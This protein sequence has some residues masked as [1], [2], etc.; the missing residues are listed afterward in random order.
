[1]RRRFAWLTPVVLTLIVAAVFVLP[2]G[3]R[4]E[5]P[6]T[7]MQRLR[8]EMWKEHVPP[9]IAEPDLGQEAK[10]DSGAVSS[11]GGL[12][13]WSRIVFQSY[14]DG[15]WEI[16]LAWG[17]GSRQTR[18]TNNSAS[19]ARPRLNRGAT[20]VVFESNR[21][22]NWEIYSM[23][24]D[25]SGVKRLT[26]NP[27]DETTAAW[28]P[29]GKKIAFA[30][31]R[32]GNYEIYVMNADGS[33]VRRLTNNS[34]DD[35]SPTWSLDGTRIAWARMAQGAYD[36]SIWTMKPDGANQSK[37]SGLLRLWFLQNVVWQP[38]SL[39]PSFGCDYDV[40]MDLWNEVALLYGWVVAIHDAGAM[41]DTW[42]GSWKPVPD[43]PS[44][45]DYTDLLF[46]RVE[47]VVQNN[48]LYIRAAYIEKHPGPSAP[49][50]M[51]PVRLISSGLDL[52]PDWQ[53]LD[54]TPPVVRV[55][56]LPPFSRTPG[57]TL[58]WSAQ[59]V[60]PAGVRNYGV[61]TKVNNGAWAECFPDGSYTTCLED[62]RDTS[63]TIRG[64]PGY[65][66]GFRVR[67]WDNAGNLQPW[68]GDEPDVKTTFY[69]WLLTGSVRDARGKLIP[70]ARVTG[71]PA[72]AVP[73][74]TNAYGDY[75]A[76]L[77]AEHTQAVRPT[78]LGYHAPPETILNLTADGTLNLVLVPT[79]N[80]ITDGG[81][82]GSVLTDA[83]APFGEPRPKA[84]A[85]TRHSGAQSLELGWPDGTSEADVDSG[86]RQQVII[87]ATL[88]RPTLS[89]L[90]H[91]RNGDCGDS[92]VIAGV[93]D[94]TGAEFLPVAVNSLGNWQ[95]AWADVGEW[96]G[97]TVTV[98][99]G[100]RQPAGAAQQNMYIDEVTLGSWLT[101]VIHEI[102]PSVIQP[103]ADTMVT[104][105][106]ENFAATPEVRFDNIVLRN[107]EFVDEQT[108]RITV[109]ADFRPGVFD[110]WV[111]NPRGHV[112]ALPG[113]MQ[114][115]VQH[116]IPMVSKSY[117]P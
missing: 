108:L 13:D 45:Y 89:L 47:Y 21:D 29:D 78:R 72:P 107:V 25:G 2:F 18:L 31:K 14:R 70:G 48:R 26:N 106:G 10:P 58:S 46:S 114:K 6:V 112:T 105:T 23:N 82:E 68:R 57:F 22:G 8:A 27:A 110:V 111:T 77:T 96:A 32:D 28:S 43:Y 81:F 98:T 16:Y 49:S 7:E 61:E 37:I 38:Y 53:T 59:D 24:A 1:M 65:T 90:Y 109:P 85:H 19:D 100:V 9:V 51:E 113:G 35:Y 12:A 66:Y 74:T 36:G 50:H 91:C 71:S 55:D 94:G 67:A 103:H 4:A 92:Q 87:P 40:D 60:G 116:Y 30:S 86:V 73:V 52:N 80:R 42:M 3:S 11:A 56:P 115:G 93:D 20:K 88:Y 79:D 117:A 64:I 83:W 69:T 54:V 102:S 97:K 104:I 76:Y 84:V 62:V 75:R 99:I 33:G 95:Q 15:N 101:P 5:P 41:A 34:A 39:H 44:F 63:V 17:D